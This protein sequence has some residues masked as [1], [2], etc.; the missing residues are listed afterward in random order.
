MN[1]AEVECILRRA[2]E[3]LEV[4]FAGVFAADMVPNVSE[5]PVCYVVN[6]DPAS[7]AGEHWVACYA[8]SPVDVEFFDSYGFSVGEYSHIRIPHTITKHNGVSLQAFDSNACGHFCIF[9]LIHRGL[10]VSLRRIV[11][12]MLMVPTALRDSLVRRFVFRT[13]RRLHIRRPCQNACVGSQCCGKRVL[14]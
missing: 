6:T 2:L 11:A 14:Q 12:R 1:T 7:K 10:G 8:Q 9:Y 13:T 4:T 5:F 3:P